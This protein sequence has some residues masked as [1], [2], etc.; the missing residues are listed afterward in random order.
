MHLVRGSREFS[1]KQEQVLDSFLGVSHS[2]E[3]H[4][5]SSKRC[6]QKLWGRAW[7][8]EPWQS[9]LCW[10]LCEPHLPWLLHSSLGKS[11]KVPCAWEGPKGPLAEPLQRSPP[12][13]WEFP[14]TVQHC[15]SKTTS[16]IRDIGSRLKSDLFG[17]F[18]F[19]FFLPPELLCGGPDLLIS[20][21]C[22]AH[23]LVFQVN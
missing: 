8:L 4:N 15:S 20:E 10:L 12:G 21:L 22:Y 23:L 9:L 2:Q 18:S 11:S 7:T 1:H 6:K 14:Q 19:L 3:A 13:L 16:S 5:R 17:S